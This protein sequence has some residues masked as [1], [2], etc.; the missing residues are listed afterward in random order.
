ML[1]IASNQRKSSQKSN[2]MINRPSMNGLK[3]HDREPY[4]DIDDC[5]L[6]RRLLVLGGHPSED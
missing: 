2:A 3:Y 6:A 4:T 1:K 5:T